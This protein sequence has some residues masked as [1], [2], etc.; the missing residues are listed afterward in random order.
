MV[1]AKPFIK[2]LRVLLWLLQLIKPKDTLADVCD[3]AV[4]AYLFIIDIGLCQITVNMSPNK[5]TDMEIMNA[6]PF[7]YGIRYII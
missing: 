5:Y 1:R 7:E 2:C 4:M 3:P 6:V